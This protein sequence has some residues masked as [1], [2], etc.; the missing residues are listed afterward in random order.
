[1][2][3]GER[4]ATFGGVARRS[5]LVRTAAEK[6]A[7]VE[8]LASEMLRDL[9]GGWV[10]AVD[11]EP[12]LVAARRF[13]A[14]VTCLSAAP[15]YGLQRLVDPDRVHL[16]VPRVRGARPA[17]GRVGVRIHRETRWTRPEAGPPVAP[18]VEVLGR[19]LRCRPTEEAVVMIDSALNKELVTIDEIAQT[20]SGPGGPHARA[21][22]EL[23]DGK[24]RSAIETLAR[25]ALRSAGLGVQAGVVITGVGEVDLL[26]EGRIVVECD[27]F[28]YHS[29]RRE[30]REDRRRDRA[31]AASGFVVL[32]FTWE[33]IVSRPRIV[34][35][36]VLQTLQRP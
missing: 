2:H 10:A 8:G 18:L 14:T 19:L 17:P 28:A 3:I 11:A 31:L 34:P 26:V 22:L 33:D 15:S 1:M 7:L 29:D 4:L 13:N 23:C 35:E 32:R 24:S 30:Y 36:A 16:A 5:E 27:G 25:L 12:S 6:R 20:L 9:G 21:T